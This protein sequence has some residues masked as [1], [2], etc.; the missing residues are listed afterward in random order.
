M[1][2]NTQAQSHDT[3]LGCIVNEQGEEV[4]ITE[5][6]IEASLQAA[7]DICLGTD[8]HNQPH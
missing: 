3:E 7:E 1:R 2:M 4:A 5:A 8:K 6:M